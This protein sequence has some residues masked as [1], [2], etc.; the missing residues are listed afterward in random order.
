VTTIK[1][2]GDGKF[3]FTVELRPVDGKRRQAHRIRAT[4]AEARAELKRVVADDASP[5]PTTNKNPRFCDFLVERWL[6][7]IEADPRLKP[8]SVM[9]Y[10]Q[11]SRHLVAQLGDVKL[12]DLAGDHFTVLYGKM[13]DGT[14]RGRP[15]AESTIRRVHVTAH[16]SLKDACKW[17]LLAWNPVDDAVAPA[18]SPARPMAWTPEQVAVFLDRARDNRWFPLFRLVATTGMRRGEVCAL[19]WSDFDGAELVVRRSRVVVEH[20]VVEGTP[21]NDRTRRVA[22]DP[23]TVEVLRRWRAQQAEERLVIGPY[24]PGDDY[25][26]TWADGN[27]VH[28][29][30]ITRTFGRVAR[31]A[32]LPPLPLHKLRHAWATSALRAG[33]DI[34]VVSGRLGHSSTRVTHDIYTA[35]VPSM[36]RAAAETVAGLYDA[37]DAVS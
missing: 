3:E 36:D 37:G 18:Q 25:C 29:D 17:R 23:G 8:L 24:W 28:P 10:R 33:V 5:R 2:N 19:R 32:G 7:A 6:P 31:A 34:K 15:Y 26:F 1:K 35:A 30:V 20:Q 21:K 4:E 9:S 12:R 14:L 27:V 16:R 11:A 22:L 13:R